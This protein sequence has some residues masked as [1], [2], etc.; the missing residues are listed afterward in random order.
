[1]A[2]GDVNISID[3]TVKGL[4]NSVQNRSPI[5]LFSTSINIVP[6]GLRDLSPSSFIPRVVS[7]GPLH[8][9]NENLKAFEDQKA[10]Y[11]HELL[12]P[13]DSPVEQTLK[14]CVLKVAFSVDR[15]RA[16]YVPKITYSD[17]ELAKMMV[18][19]ACFILGFIGALS[20]SSDEPEL[21]YLLRGSSIVYDLVL[22]ENQIPFFILQDI[23]D[24]TILKSKPTASLTDLILQ[25]IQVF[26]VF[27]SNITISNV[28][29]FVPLD[30]ILG[31][32]DRCYWPS[33]EYSPSQGL[34]SSAI[35]STVELERA[36]MIFQCNQDHERWQMD[37]EFISSKFSCFSWCWG[38]PTLRMPVLRIDNFTEL[39]LRN[40][41]AYEQ[42]SG[43][44]TYV[45]SY[46]MAMD[47]L[48]DNQEDIAKLIDSKVVVNH[49]GSNEKAANMMNSLCKELPLL[50]FYYIDIWRQMDTHY[51][52][53][54]PKNISALKRT[55][56]S[57]PWN[58][59]ALLA[60]IAL[61]ALTIVQTIYTVNAA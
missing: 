27:Q 46:A 43:F 45:T 29:P 34:P 44:R 12:H 26:N 36:G 19:D 41:I 49:L 31:F 42:S 10:T 40:L 15:I 24:C 6:S 47:M 17:M 52:S 18:M 61:F 32:L 16:S 14:E 53:Y 60:G 57:S 4:L 13:L 21:Q 35:H 55:Y 33:V 51:N 38:K 59:I 2:D 23:F 3:E 58:M 48:V 50:S 28:Y 30:H 39:I 37:M 54:W 7:I 56:F 11:V 9:E 1:M 5:D 8:K 25:L 22:V 20:E